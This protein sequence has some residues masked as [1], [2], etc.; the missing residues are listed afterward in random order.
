[1]SLTD[2]TFVEGVQLD[3]VLTILGNN[4]V[5]FE[6]VKK[7]G[8]SN[9]YLVESILVAL[10]LDQDHIRDFFSQRFQGPASRKSL[11]K[12]WNLD[13][14]LNINL[15]HASRSSPI[16][17]FAYHDMAPGFSLED[18]TG[19]PNV[20]KGKVVESTYI[21]PGQGYETTPF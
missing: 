2:L 1:M 10:D 14:R 8:N 17:L 4:N 9:L 3:D 12:K 13:R 15:G 7:H 11:T 6:I 16:V 20:R 19:R 21:I 18:Y 5:Q